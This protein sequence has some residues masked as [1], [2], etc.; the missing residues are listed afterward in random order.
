MVT[1]LY[2]V[3]P[4]PLLPSH[5]IL[6]I[7]VPVKL[8]IKTDRTPNITKTFG[9]KKMY[10]LKHSLWLIVAPDPTHFPAYIELVLLHSSKADF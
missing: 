2:S 1:T 10:L 9:W 3:G 7:P 6:E 8:L 4:T 5:A